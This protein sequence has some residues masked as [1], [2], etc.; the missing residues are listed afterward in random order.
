[1][2]KVAAVTGAAGGIG[3]AVARGFAAEGYS[4]ALIDVKGDA[5]DAVVADPTFAHVQTASIVADIADA[6]SCASAMNGALE[7][8]GRVDVLVNNA[9]VG[10][11]S[12]LEDLSVEDID[13]VLDV[14]SRG[15]ILLSRAI[16]PHMAERGS[17]SIVNISSISAKLGAANIAPYSASKAALIGFTR[18]LA[19]ELAP[20]GIRVNAVCP[21]STNTPMMDNNIRMTMEEKGITYEEAHALWVAN[22]PTKVMIEPE[23]IADAVLFLASDRARM[24]TGE[25]L[26]V[27]AGVVMW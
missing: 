27:S 23:D 11:S 24:I 12:A 15:P 4:I 20:K 2:S 14:N 21:G 5:L 18:A 9:G 17:G 13:D 10:F 22:V 26:N 25:S 6:E 7:A 8:L 16:V 1:M 3:K 19:M